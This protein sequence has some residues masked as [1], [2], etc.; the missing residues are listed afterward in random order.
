[1]GADYLARVRPLAQD[2]ARIIDKMPGNFHFVG[3]VH[4]ALPNAR[5]IHMRRDPIDTCLSCFSKNFTA[6]HAFTCDLGE[7]GRYFA[8]YQSLM[9]HW[10]DVLPPGVMLAVQ[11]EDV[12]ADLEGQARRLVAHCGLE[13]DDACLTFHKTER[14][15]KTASAAQVR[16][17]IYGTSVARWRPAPEVL[18]P[19]LA[20]LGEAG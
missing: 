6:G 18:A 16:K 12:V 4:L 20:G 13:W 3:L 19:L 5:I 9:A 11:Y 17:P 14:L 10:R 8:S 7:L 15:V 1:L 2:A